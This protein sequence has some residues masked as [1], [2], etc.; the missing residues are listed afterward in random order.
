MRIGS[1][2]QTG[3]L[4]QLFALSEGAVDLAVSYNVFSD[5]RINAGYMTQQRS[6]GG[7]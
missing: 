4:Q 1:R 5:S 3:D 7:V 2:T 6:L